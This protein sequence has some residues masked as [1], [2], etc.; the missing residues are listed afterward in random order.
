MATVNLGAIKFNW[1]G[2]YNNSTAY[3]V[4][5]VVSSGGS[6]YVC[7]LASQGNAV[8]NGTYW[9]QMS[10][11]GTNGTNGTNGTDV[12]TVITTQGDIL[13]RDGSGLQRL[14]K[15]TAG[16]VLQMNSGATAPEYG[17]V[18]SDFVRITTNTL[19]S[20]TTTWSIDNVFSATYKNYIIKLNLRTGDNNH[21][22]KFRYLNN[23]GSEVGD[24]Y[25]RGGAGG[26]E[27][28]SSGANNGQVKHDWNDNGHQLTGFG[29]TLGNNGTP[30]AINLTATINIAYPNVS[31]GFGFPGKSMNGLVN[32]TGTSGARVLL[33][34]IGGYFDAN[35]QAR[36]FNIVSTTGNGIGANSMLAVYGLKS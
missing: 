14:P 20:A 11:A 25:Y 5:D 12:G 36:G 22:I 15:G 27:S 3:V 7:I 29:D 30:D 2:A 17:T 6:S 28:T 24:A 10:S 34:Y 13:Y 32:Y 21:N 26:F 19:G 16:Q 33:G 9:N 23:S 4:D 31:S 8:S 35:L 18:S 1:K